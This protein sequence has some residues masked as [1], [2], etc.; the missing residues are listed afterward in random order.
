M[1]GYFTLWNLLHNLPCSP[2]VP[3]DHADLKKN[4][5]LCRGCNEYQSSTNFPLKTNESAVGLCRHC[6]ELDNEARRREDFSLYKNILR[7]LRD[8]E[9]ECSPGAKITYLLQVK[10][11][12]VVVNQ[13]VVVIV[14]E[15][16]WWFSQHLP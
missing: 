6:M 10:F 12:H 16:A 2:Q 11:M 7:C 9:V 8:T 3:R 14:L 13:I 5:Y 1:I 15:K 4:I